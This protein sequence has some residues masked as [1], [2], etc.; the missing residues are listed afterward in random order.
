MSHA[1]TEASV[2]VNGISG[3]FVQARDP[4]ALAHWYADHLG[5]DFHFWEDRGSYGLEFVSRDSVPSDPTTREG[6]VFVIEPGD[7]ADG[8][9]GVRVQHRVRDLDAL[10]RQ[11]ASAG[12]TPVSDQ[13]H[14]FGRF[15]RFHD[16]EGNEF[17]LYEPR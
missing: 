14:A 13:E 11:L 1:A 6:T 7:G 17:E 9:A 8:P 5:L 12:V 15:A 16:P 10:L 2:K 4:E 3:V